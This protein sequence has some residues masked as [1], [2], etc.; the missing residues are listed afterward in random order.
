MAL[1]GFFA[2]SG[3]PVGLNC[4]LHLSVSVFAVLS[5]GDLLTFLLASFSPFIL[6]T[7][8]CPWLRAALFC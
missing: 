2:F 4:G 8:N 5:T 1:L 7:V 6:L 3:M